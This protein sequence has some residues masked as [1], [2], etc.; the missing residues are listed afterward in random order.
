MV[1]D[2]TLVLFAV[3]A[4]SSFQLVTGRGTVVYQSLDWWLFSRHLRG[5]PH[6]DDLL[7]PRVKVFV[8]APPADPG[9]LQILDGAERA[10]ATRPP[11]VRRRTRGHR[12]A[13]RPDRV[14]AAARH[15]G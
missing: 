9:A 11:P 3:M 13:G 12:S 1:D 4:G 5:V 15:R 10:F 2:G 8:G 6:D 14:R 7:A